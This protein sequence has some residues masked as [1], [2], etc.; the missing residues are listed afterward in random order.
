MF[1]K[2]EEC[3]CELYFWWITTWLVCKWEFWIPLVSIFLIY[4]CLSSQHTYSQGLQTLPATL[5]LTYECP[6]PTCYSQQFQWKNNVYFFFISD[7]S[8]LRSDGVLHHLPLLNHLH[9]S[10][11]LF[12]INL[13]RTRMSQMPAILCLLYLSSMS[14]LG[15]YSSHLFM[16]TV[17][18][19]VLI[20]KKHPIS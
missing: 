8:A 7:N 17:F 13:N 18:L 6:V 19:S 1:Y 9:P 10:V 20:E 14:H 2:D 12:V 5:G 3:S 11:N 15:L 16:I 4:L